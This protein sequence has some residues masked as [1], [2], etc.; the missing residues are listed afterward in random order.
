MSEDKELCQN[1]G[2]KQPKT[3]KQA[4]PIP[5]PPQS[6]SLDDD[7]QNH[8]HDS[9]TQSDDT[10]HTIIEQTESGQ[11]QSDKR[12]DPSGTDTKKTSRRVII[13]IIAAVVALVVLLVAFLIL[14]PIASRA[15]LDGTTGAPTG[16]WSMNIK[17]RGA[18]IKAIKVKVEPDGNTQLDILN[19]P[20]A[21]GKLVSEKS[22]ATQITY[23]VQNLTA[24]DGRLAGMA[25]HTSASITIPRKGIEG[26]WK[27]QMQLNGSIPI[28]YAMNVRKNNTILFTWKNPLQSGSTNGKWEQIGA[29]DGKKSYSVSLPTQIMPIDP[30][31]PTLYGTLDFEIP[32][33]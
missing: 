24:L 12:C 2:A 17:A 15:K 14:K 26:T 23:D 20:T 25:Q 22:D 32:D 11:S 28:D 9:S 21:T 19:K 6:N 5:I 3:P 16:T 10:G 31:L 13:A 7:L 8:P 30:D 29:K 33:R 4:T 18:S 27:I 1:C